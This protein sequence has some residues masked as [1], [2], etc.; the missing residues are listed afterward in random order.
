MPMPVPCINKKP[1]PLY[2]FVELRRP[3]IKLSNINK[4]RLKESIKITIHVK[5]FLSKWLNSYIAKK[6]Y[7]IFLEEL[8]IFLRKFE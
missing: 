5:H 7:D 3:K 1:S 8:S 6:M 4:K 2:V